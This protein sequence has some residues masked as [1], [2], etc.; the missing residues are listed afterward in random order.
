MGYEF[1]IILNREI[2]D[3]ESK[4]LLENCVGTT[5]S[6]AP[7]PT[8]AD[9]TGTQLEVDNTEAPTLAEAI[10][11][12]LDAV[13]LV[14]DV[15]PASLSVPA[16]PNGEPPEGETEESGQTPPV[17]QDTGPTPSIIQGTVE[18]GTAETVI[19]GGTEPTDDAETGPADDATVTA[20]TETAPAA[21]DDEPMPATAGA[22]NPDSAG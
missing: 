8:N 15:L 2:T 17:S 12:A 20:S 18:Q 19:T 16:Q 11:S 3:D 9:V 6:T 21:A 13:K 14:P 22:G 7:L 4:V 10:Q 1:S 5:L